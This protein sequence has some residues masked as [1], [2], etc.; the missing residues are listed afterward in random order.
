MRGAALALVAMCAVARAQQMPCEPCVRGDDTLSQLGSGGVAL[1]SNISLLN[2]S[3][4]A[5]GQWSQ[6]MQQRFQETI[7][8]E[9]GHRLS[10]LSDTQLTEVAAA[11]CGA[12]DGACVTNVVGN[13]NC[14]AGRCAMF[15][16]QERDH[17]M[18]PPDPPNTC[19]PTVDHVRSPAKGI[20]FEWATGW[21]DDAAPTD[22]RAWSLGFEARTRLQK[23]FGLVARVDRSTGRD[24]AEDSNRDGRDDIATGAVTRL[25]LM[26]GPSYFFAV[27]HDKDVV[28]FAQ[29]DLLG[30]YL[31]TL[32][33]DHHGFAAGADLSYTL[34]VARIGMRYTQ[35]LGGAQDARAAL[36]HVGFLVGGAPSFDYGSGCGEE[37][38]TPTKLALALDLPLF[39]YGM[40]KQL[41]YVLPGFGVEALWHMTPS[42]DALVHG[43][44][45]DTPLGNRDRAIYQTLLAGVRL[46]LAS[47]EGE[48]GT[49]TGIFSTL[50]A[51]Y[52]WA[53]TTDPSA[54]AGSGPV[55]EAAIAWGGQGDDGG[56][57]LKVHARFGLTPDNEQFR[58]LF[59]SGGLELRLDRRKWRD[60]MGGKNE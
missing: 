15:V 53:A 18:R 54:A 23:R 14:L 56:A 38:R 16:E 50:S 34:A 44:I 24:R 3:L 58:A 28:R 57:Y 36:F 55:A 33:Q 5:P 59:L 37:T 10:E 27:G 12:P 6:A 46:D 41:D 48:H 25:S 40:S 13:L 30:G 39:G 2:N 52:T 32:E 29:L 35:G 8:P 7:G 17:V 20:G 11:L 26:A 47:R 60:R 21:Q 4:P 1:R 43:D 42:F 22:H 31:W 45:I 49:K 51:G 19:D 9:V